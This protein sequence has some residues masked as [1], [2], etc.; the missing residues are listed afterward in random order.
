MNPPDLTQL[1]GTTGL[2]LVLIW[3]VK[4]LATRLETTTTTLISTLQTR[5]EENTRALDRNSA[6]LEVCRTRNGDTVRIERDAPC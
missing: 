1:A 4:Y 5:L 6:V 2:I 3:A